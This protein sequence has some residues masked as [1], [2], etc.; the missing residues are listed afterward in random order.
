MAIELARQDTSEIQAAEHDRTLYYD[1]KWKQFV[2]DLFV[3]F[4]KGSPGR[5]GLE[6][7]LKG[8]KVGC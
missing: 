8:N 2:A 3:L 6:K 7:S 1:Q 4:P 5:E